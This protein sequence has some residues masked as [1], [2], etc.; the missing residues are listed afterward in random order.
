MFD[1]VPSCLRTYTNHQD[2]GSL[3]TF[4]RICRPLDNADFFKRLLLRPLKDGIPS[5]AELLRVRT[6]AANG[7]IH[8][9]CF[10]ALMSHVCLR[11]TKEVWKNSRKPRHGNSNRIP[12]ARRLRKSFGTV[13]SGMCELCLQ[14]GTV[15]DFRHRSKSSKFLLH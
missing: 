3:L 15:V 9:H 8:E 5:G 2:L 4:L 11:R 6:I 10:Q 7:S 14:S 13:A 1:L 12:D